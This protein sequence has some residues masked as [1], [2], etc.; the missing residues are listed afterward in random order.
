QRGLRAPRGVLDLGNS[1]T[2]IR[3][4]MGL[5]AGQPFDSEL[6]GDASLRQR[7]ME[8]VAAPLRLMGARITTSGGGR[9]PVAIGGGARLRGCDYE[10][11]MASAQ[12]KSALLLAALN[13]EGT[14]T[15]RSPGPSRDHT[16]RMLESMG[17]RLG[18]AAAGAGHVVTLTGP[19][20]LRGFEIRV[21][22]DFSSAAFFLVAGCLGARDGLLIENVGVNPTRTGLLTILRE[23]GA[24]IELRNQRS[25]G[26][27]PVADLWVTQSELKGIAV[28][29]EL[30][31]LAIDEFPI[32]FI[33]AAAAAGETVV[34]GAEELRKKET[35][36]IAVMARGL[37]AVGVK[38]EERPDGARIIGRGALRGGSVD[39]RG[40]HR[41]A[42][43]F[44]V[45]S[46]K[47]SSAIE[48]LNTAEVATSFPNFLDVAAAVG[49]RVSAAEDSA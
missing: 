11:P 4:L 17:V 46:L 41:I 40:D 24:T 49:L 32:L 47:A 14:T 13:A 5:L 39:S 36:R 28:P 43:S 19:A 15:V 3:L 16:E 6:T 45:A 20:R 22:A 10:L 30:V 27:E 48:I 35:D 26:A 9:P 18:L 33:A 23:M 38:V 8:R 37:E 44:A 7:P 31:P 34:G 42:M 21:P 29:P 2:A 12:V 25:V 1:G